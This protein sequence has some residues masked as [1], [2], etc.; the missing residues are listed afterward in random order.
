MHDPCRACALG[1]ALET[2]IGERLAETDEAGQ[3]RLELVRHV[4][5]KIVLDPARPLDCLGHA[6]ERRTKLA[7]LVRTAYADAA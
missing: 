7:D 4:R 6:I 3:R 2:A 5:K 1:L